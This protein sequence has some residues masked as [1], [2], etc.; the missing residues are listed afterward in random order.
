M[1]VAAQQVGVLAQASR[2][3]SD[4]SRQAAESLA[5]LRGAIT[6]ISSS[7]GP[8]L[9]GGGRPG[10]PRRRR[11]DRRTAERERVDHRDGPVDLGDQPAEPLPRA[12]RLRGGRARR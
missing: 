3:V 1:E 5:E 9:L 11:A 12:Q 6:D 7:A 10:R 4:T 8:R 2:E